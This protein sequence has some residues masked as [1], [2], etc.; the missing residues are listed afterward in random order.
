MITAAQTWSLSKSR[1][2]LQSPLVAAPS[3]AETIIARSRNGTGTQRGSCSNTANRSI[4]LRST[5]AKSH[6]LRPDCCESRQ[7]PM[8]RLP[9]IV[10]PTMQEQ[11]EFGRSRKTAWNPS[12]STSR[13]LRTTSICL[14]S[15]RNSASRATC[16]LFLSN[17][18]SLPH[19]WEQVMLRGTSTPSTTR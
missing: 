16:G 7:R 12:S 15:A 14:L 6:S 19:S 18:D 2:R 3:P 10:V 11:R 13:E 5:S 9:G 8:T 1:N 4:C 17:R